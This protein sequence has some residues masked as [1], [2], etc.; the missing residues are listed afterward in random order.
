MK[1]V[2][3]LGARTSGRGG[4]CAYVDGAAYVDEDRDFFKGD[5][6]EDVV[7]RLSGDSAVPGIDGFV[8]G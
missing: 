2:I 1:R 3:K 7:F 6:D 4:K 8:E 5:E